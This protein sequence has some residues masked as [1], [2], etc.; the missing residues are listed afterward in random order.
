M[1]N[2][3]EWSGKKGSPPPLLPK[4]SKYR[5][6]SVFVILLHIA[7]VGIIHRHS[8]RACTTPPEEQADDNP[9]TKYLPH[10][11]HLT[12]AREQSGILLVR[13]RDYRIPQVE[14]D[15]GHKQDDNNQCDDHRSN[16]PSGHRL[17]GC[18]CDKIF[19]GG[20]GALDNGLDG[21]GDHGWIGGNECVRS[22]EREKVRKQRYFKNGCDRCCGYFFLRTEHN[23]LCET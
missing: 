5:T 10:R 18:T 16:T 8:L 17:V 23:T 1:D 6:T 11:I 20:T 12:N 9:Q 21:L 2:M 15:K 7:T 3:L 13:T 22:E 19:A 4:R 14:P